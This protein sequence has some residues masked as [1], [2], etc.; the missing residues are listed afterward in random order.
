MLYLYC[1]YSLRFFTVDCGEINFSVLLFHFR[2]ELDLTAQIHLFFFTLQNGAAPSTA[3][4]QKTP[5]RS[6][7]NQK[8][9]GILNPS[10]TY[11]IIGIATKSIHL[12]QESVG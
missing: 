5:P 6:E 10:T 4:N 7:E 12:P 11:P 2:T 1:S 8:H 3:A 9:Y